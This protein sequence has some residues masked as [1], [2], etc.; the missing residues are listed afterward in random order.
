MREM[1]KT[2]Y[3]LIASLGTLLFPTTSLA[4]YDAMF[5]QY[6]YNEMFIN[7]G[8]TG[9]REA[10]SATLLHRQQWMNFPGRPVTTTFSLHGPLCQNKMGLGLSVLNE[11]IGV[12]NRN[13]AYLSYAY[14]I[15]TGDNGRLALG[16]AGGI[17]NQANRFPDLKTSRDGSIDPQLAQN[18]NLTAFNFGAGLYFSTKTFYAGLS[19]PRVIDDRVVFSDGSPSAATGIDPSALHYYLTLGKYFDL[20]RNTAFKAQAMLKSVAGAP[21]Q[22]DI[23]ANFLFYQKLWLGAG[24]RTNAAAVAL[25]GLQITP[26]LFAGYSYDF[27]LNGLQTYSGGSHEIV[28]SYL[29]LFDLKK[30]LSPRYF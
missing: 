3:I 22:A 23:N 27:D 18:A 17:H 28:L 14:R 1:K 6:M 15:K 2:S 7:P 10:M 30:T 21:I 26:Q 24:Y 13:L 8:Y 12:L 9:S 5:T 11:K 20:S 25:L 16:L 19:V 29:F 4:Q